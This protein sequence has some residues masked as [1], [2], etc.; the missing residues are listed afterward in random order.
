M[1]EWE[2][3]HA[4]ALEMLADNEAKHGWPSMHPPGTPFD[5]IHDADNQRADRVIT[6]AIVSGETHDYEDLVGMTGRLGRAYGPRVLYNLDYHGLLEPAAYVRGVGHVW[7]L[8][9]YPGV[10]LDRDDWRRLFRKAGFT[11]DGELADRP[12]D[13]IRLYRGSPNAHKRNFSWTPD[14]SRAEHFVRARTFG[15]HQAYL[16]TTLAP[17]S[18]LL[19]YIHESG[20]G[21]DEWVIDTRGLEIIAAD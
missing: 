6:A 4:E 17:P 14:R 18:S 19:A 15:S 3:W 1:A 11:I 9:E 20:R 12:A 5:A 10:A 2:A 21:E 8:A 16:W 7:G 13:P